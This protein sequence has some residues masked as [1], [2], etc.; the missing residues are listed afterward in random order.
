MQPLLPG[1]ATCLVLVTS[2]NHL[3]G[4]ETTHAVSLDTLPLADAVTLFLNTADRPELTTETPDVLDVVQLCG[5]LPLAIRIAAARLKH[6]RV[7]TVADLIARLRDV[8]GLAAFDDGQRSVHATLHLSY[9][10]LSPAAQRLYRLLGLHPGPDVEPYAAAALTAGTLDEARRLLD[11][12][13]DDHMLQE[14]SPGRFQFH[15]LVRAH[16]ADIAVAQETPATAAG[17]ADP[18]AGP[19]PPHRSDGDGDGLP[20]STAASPHGPTRAHRDPRPG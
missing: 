9:Q 19:L 11:G 17:G 3:T 14:P 20:P 15:D 1:A 13:V 10:H 2:R 16:A 4:L 8:A 6:R 7:W 12:L 18:V 5:R